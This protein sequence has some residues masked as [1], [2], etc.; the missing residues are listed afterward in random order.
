M[1]G[2]EGEGE[3]AE[4]VREGEAIDITTDTLLPIL[5][6]ISMCAQLV[7]PYYYHDSC[8]TAGLVWRLL[9]AKSQWKQE[10][11]SSSELFAHN[12]LF[13]SLLTASRTSIGSITPPPDYDTVYRI[14]TEVLL[15]YSHMWY[16]VVSC[17]DECMYIAHV[18][19]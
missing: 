6:L 8:Q 11:T 5:P 15:Y 7:L 18:T 19:V 17:K 3:K 14:L 12:L 9:N 4:G 13:V 16:I 2:R 1:G 10:F